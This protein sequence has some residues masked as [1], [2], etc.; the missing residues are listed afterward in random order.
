M[1]AQHRTYWRY[2]FAGETKSNRPSVAPVCDPP[3]PSRRDR[4]IGNTNT[5]GQGN[6]PAPVHQ[7]PSNPSQ[8]SFCPL[9]RLLDR[10]VLFTYDRLTGIEP[11][12]TFSSCA[13]RTYHYFNWRT[14]NGG[15]VS[16]LP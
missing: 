10:V 11:A 16:N 14:F 13:V 7:S 4:L 15:P 12:L 9:R 3:P 2:F 8:R 6:G 5:M 1:E